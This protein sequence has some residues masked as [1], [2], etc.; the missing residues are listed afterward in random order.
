[1]S[2]WPRK[3]AEDYCRNGIVISVDGIETVVR[4]ARD[5]ALEEAAQAAEAGYRPGVEVANAAERL[6]ASRIRAL[7][8]KP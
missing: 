8:G 5:S 1:M 6:A 4:A 7:K 2:D 3:L